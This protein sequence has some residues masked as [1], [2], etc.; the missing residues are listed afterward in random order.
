M[1]IR[2]ERIYLEVRS[3]AAH[4]QPAMF[5]RKSAQ[6]NL[7]KA[8]CILSPSAGRDLHLTDKGLPKRMSTFYCLIHSYALLSRVKTCASC[9]VNVITELIVLASNI[10]IT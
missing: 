6:N 3:G 7:H 5:R 2:P 10:I 4:C 1:L 8:K 9:K